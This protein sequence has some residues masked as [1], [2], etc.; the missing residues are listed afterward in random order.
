MRRQRVTACVVL[1]TMVGILAHGGARAGWIQTSVYGGP[2]RAASAFDGESAWL[3]GGVRY[4]PGSFRQLGIEAHPLDTIYRFDGPDQQ[5]TLVGNLPYEMHGASAVWVGNHAF[6]FGG[7]TG[8]SYPE[9]SV[10]AGDAHDEILRFDPL[11]GSITVMTTKLPTPRMFMASAWDGEHVYLFG[12]RGRA[13]GVQVTYDD[14]LRYNPQTDSLEKLFSKLPLPRIDASAIWDGED[15]YVF[16]GVLP[17]NEHIEDILRFDPRS[18]AL[19]T[20]RAKTP[21]MAGIAPSF[22]GESIFIFGGYYQN[23]QMSSSTLRQVCEGCFV[24]FIFRYDQE[25]DLLITMSQR[26]T[27]RRAWASVAWSTPVF[28]VIGGTN[29]NSDAL[30]VEIYSPS[31]GPPQNVTAEPGDSLGDARATWRPPS[32]DSYSTVTGY[33]VYGG[34]SS[35]QLQ[36]VAE[37]GPDTQEWLF[38]GLDARSDYYVAVSALWHEGEGTQSSPTRVRPRGEFVLDLLPL[39]VPIT[40]S[41]TAYAT[42]TATRNP[43]FSGPVTLTAEALPAGFS[44]TFTENPLTSDS[45]QMEISAAPGVELGPHRFDVVGASPESVSGAIP[46]TAM[47]V[48]PDGYVNGAP[49]R[50]MAASYSGT[51]TLR[52]HFPLGD[53]EKVI[54]TLKVIDELHGA[55]L[56][57]W[58]YGYEDYI[59]HGYPYREWHPVRGGWGCG[60]IKNILL[61]YPWWENSGMRQLRVYPTTAGYV[62]GA[63]D[64]AG[65]TAKGTV[66]AKVGS[67]VP[68]L[69]SDPPKFYHAGGHEECG[70]DCILFDI[71]SDETGVASIVVEDSLAEAL[72]YEWLVLDAQWSMRASGTAC[73]SEFKG[74][75]LPTGSRYLVIRPMRPDPFNPCRGIHTPMPTSGKVDVAFTR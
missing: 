68:S 49:V 53:D 9:R 3:F 7:C 57:R 24:R 4:V 18:S 42:I 41:S 46:M 44:V 26:L 75:S 14:I 22:D 11:T 27:R 58:E 69:R 71:R 66:Y 48:P 19:E 39:E 10:C 72:D 51:T 45:T 61:E 23:S 54:T 32:L 38:T 13:G 52:S 50:T 31:P 67:G 12:G 63:C 30:P 16:G 29:W 73:R 2:G 62:P 17:T 70:R 36:L 40:P 64:E 59:P 25:H 1:M 47:V 60:E 28:W 37:L 43:G 6:I 34:T 21:P 33:R 20:M 5:L 15:I 56:F 65:L 74:R 35:D 55:A 8:W